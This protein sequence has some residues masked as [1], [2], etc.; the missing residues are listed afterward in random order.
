MRLMRPGPARWPMVV[1]VG[2]GL[3]AVLPAAEDAFLRVCRT[4][5]H[6]VYKAMLECVRVNGGYVPPA[7][8]HPD[9]KAPVPGQGAWTAYLG[10]YLQR[11]GER[12][13][14]T[15]VHGKKQPE[16]T[17]FHCPANPYWSGGFGP[18]CTG[19]AWNTNLGMFGA[20]SDPETVR[21]VRFDR[22]A[23]KRHTILMTDAGA[24]PGH[25]PHCHY[26]ARSKAQ[27]GYWH[28]GKANVL[29]MDGHIE[30]LSPKEID[31]RWFRIRLE[32]VT[33]R[34]TRQTKEKK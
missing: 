25:G 34:P 26:H 13:L 10:P 33:T 24:M 27:V 21:L 32:P 1:A 6:T 18:G 7:Y 15:Y 2:L 11:M 23:D 16:N 29:F 30:T 12:T 17:I 3:P 8:M 28:A 31:D 4:K 22:V 20:K 9:L 5:M 14:G 19:Y